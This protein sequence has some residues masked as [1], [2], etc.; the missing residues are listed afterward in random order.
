VD[1]LR[2]KEKTLVGDV[3][4]AAAFMSYI[5][6]FDKRYRDELVQEHWLP[7]IRENAVPMSDGARDSYAD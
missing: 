1:S 3:L 7:Y 4:L 6:A 5:G 2:H